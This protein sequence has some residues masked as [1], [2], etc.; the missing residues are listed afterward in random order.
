[1]DV[2]QEVEWQHV[3]QRDAVEASTVV[4]GVRHDRAGGDLHQQHGNDDQKILTRLALAFG[5]RAESS[6]HQVH[7]CVVWMVEPEL[8][9]EQHQ[10]ER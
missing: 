9:D 4:V 3:M 6:Q 10:A 2:A 5:Q 7:W 1:M 8:V